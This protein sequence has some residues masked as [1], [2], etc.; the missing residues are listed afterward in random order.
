MLIS[1]KLM[2]GAAAGLAATLATTATATSAG[3]VAVKVAM[4]CSHDPGGR[5]YAAMVTMPY[6]GVPGSTFK[7]RIDGVPTGPIA[8]TGL[9]YIHEMITDYRIPAGTTYVA[10]S[11]RIVP[12]TGTPNARA[13]A[14]VWHDAG[15]IHIDLPAHIDNGQGYTAP[16]LEF[17]LRIDAPA[18][19]V[20]A[21]QFE[22]YEVLANVILLG[23]LRS[24][25]EPRPK[26]YTI[27]QTRVAPAPSEP[28]DPSE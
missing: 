22:H 27:G 14:R 9:N 23:D 1:W 7:V 24:S 8:H 5:S 4:E 15:G 2:C 18:G 13:G 28:S 10:D 11:L 16:T 17:D 12:D 6:S 20:L 25:C 26:P 3:P 21:L 19:T